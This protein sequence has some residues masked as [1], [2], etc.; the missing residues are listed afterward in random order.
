MTKLLLI[1]GMPGCGKGEFINIANGF[2]YTPVV[3]GDI[4]RE[5]TVKRGREIKESGMVAQQLRMENG[6][7]AIAMLTIPR[8]KDGRKYIIDG[9]R[10]YS[11]VLEFKK[12]FD[13]V[14]VGIHCA[15]S[16]R[17][18][19][20]YD[21]EREDDPS[22]YEEFTERDHR[23]LGFGIGDAIALSDMM[24]INEDGLDDFQDRCKEVLRKLEKDEY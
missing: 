13:S 21:R 11:E 3:M 6:N 10:G 19:R 17:F 22:D 1:V 2:G 9:I 8:L 23:E 15:P 7:S 20:L 4:V 5:E 18:Q 16:L 24:I 14:I 12:Q